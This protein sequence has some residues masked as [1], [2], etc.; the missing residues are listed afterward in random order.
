MKN[1]AIKT[2]IA[3][4]VT[5]GSV[6][7][8]SNTLFSQSPPPPPDNHGEQGDNSPQG[9]SAPIGSGLTL[10]L[11]MGAAYGA[12]KIYSLKKTEKN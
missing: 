10:L 5:A 12:K 7:I 4:L 3:V 2:A 6:L 8:C 1:S 9:G 11:T